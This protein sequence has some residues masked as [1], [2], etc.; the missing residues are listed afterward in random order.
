[1]LKEKFYEVAKRLG[2]KTPEA[3]RILAELGFEV[4][5]N[6]TRISDEAIN[7]LMVALDGRAM[8]AE[9]EIK[10]QE[11]PAANLDQEPSAPEEV[12]F[13][14]PSKNHD[15]AYKKE[16]Y[17]PGTPKIME[18]AQSIRFEDYE[19]R[20]SDLEKIEFIKKQR[21]FTVRSTSYPKGKIRIV[22]EAELARLKIGR[23]PK[24]TEVKSTDDQKLAGA[25]PEVVR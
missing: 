15:I 19:Y 25:F 4:K 1:M 5:S 14:S 9:P 22:T 23:Q 7:A 18:Q 3:K 13:F 16:T 12:I 17:F 20:T 6:F 10:P 8:R 24:V 11:T 21:S 2:V